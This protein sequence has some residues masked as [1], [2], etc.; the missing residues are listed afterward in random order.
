M[1]RKMEIK[2]E[3]F[4]HGGRN[5]TGLDALNLQKKWKK[6]GRRVNGNFYG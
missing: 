6:M 5:N 3:V 1:Q 4:T 2:W